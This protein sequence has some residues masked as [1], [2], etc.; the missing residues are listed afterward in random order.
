[1]RFSALL[2][3]RLWFGFGFGFGSCSDLDSASNDCVFALVESFSILYRWLNPNAIL[4]SLLRLWS[5]W[6]PAQSAFNGPIKTLVES[7]FGT[8]SLFEWNWTLASIEA[9]LHRAPMYCIVSSCSSRLDWSYQD[10]RRVFFHFNSDFCKDSRPIEP[11]LELKARQDP[12]QWYR[13]KRK[14]TGSS[15][16]FQS[17]YWSRNTLTLTNIFTFQQSANVSLQKR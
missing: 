15:L 4:C 8:L 11:Q 7:F 3:I 1:M 5:Q 13:I 12:L 14:R 2:R 6:P 17:S 10:S 9:A 16:R